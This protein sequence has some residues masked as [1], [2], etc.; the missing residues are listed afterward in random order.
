MQDRPESGIRDAFPLVLEP[1]SRLRA[2]LPL[3]LRE[4]HA[5]PISGSM[6][7]RTSRP[8][9][10]SR[11]TCPRCCGRSCAGHP[12]RGSGW[13]SARPRM[14]TS[15]ARGGTGSP[16]AAWKRCATTQTPISI[17]TKST[18]ILRDLDLLTELARGP[19]AT[20]YF[21]ITTLD[22][23]I[24]RLLEPG[25]PPPH[26][27]LEVLCRLARGGGT[28]LRSLPRADPAR[29]HRLG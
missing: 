27:R 9:S 1:L 6:P 19:G 2:W 28:P 17:V 3:L 16:G 21:T 11:P 8:R 10:S 18:L 4:S 26:K 14:P 20:V 12:G 23:G 13:R 15:P 5:T 22:P 25:T 7:T 29:R 24:W